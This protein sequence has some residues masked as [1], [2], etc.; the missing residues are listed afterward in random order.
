MA[1]TNSIT[2]RGC[3]GRDA[4]VR[5]TNAG[6]QVCSVSMAHSQGRDADSMWLD[7]VAWEG[8]G[9]G[10]AFKDLSAA[11]K[12]TWVTV[13]GR[14]KSRSWENNGQKNTRFEVV[15]TAIDCPPPKDGKRPQHSGRSEQQSESQDEIPW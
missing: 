9:Q 10:F 5:S 6:R 15:I 7:L 14:L 3:L 11:T 12:G 13:T 2:I 8:D 4:E 1:I